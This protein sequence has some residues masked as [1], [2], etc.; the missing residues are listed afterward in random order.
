VKYGILSQTHPEYQAER[1]AELEVLYRG[2]AAITDAWRRKFLP[3]HVNETPARY[4]N[5]IQAAAYL[6]YFG[7]VV[8]FFATALFCKTLSLRAANGQV[9]EV[10]YAAFA[11]DADRKGNSFEAIIKQALTTAMVKRRSLVAV[12]LPRPTT[13]PTSRFEEERLG[14]GVPYAYEVPLEQ[15]IDWQLGDDGSFRWAILKRV[16]CERTSPASTRA[17]FAEEF[18]LWE[19]VDGDVGRRAAW[20]LFRT[21]EQRVDARRA[22]PPNRDVPEIDAGV[23]SFTR[24]PLVQLELP[25]ELCLGE[26]VGGAAKEHFQRRSALIA[27]EDR[28]L[29]A[30]PYVTLGPQVSGV[31]E[32]VLADVAQDHNRGDDPAEQFIRRGFMVLA[33]D[34]KV[35]FAE[36]SGAAYELTDRQLD[37]LVDEIFRVAHQMAQSIKSTGTALERS[38]TSKRE[39]RHA[40]EIVLGAFGKAVRSLA[41]NIYDTIAGGRGEDVYWQASGLDSYEIWDR[42]ELVAEGTQVKQVAIP[43]KTFQREYFG[44]VAT[45]LLGDVTPETLATI[46]DEIADA[47]AN[48]PAPGEATQAPPS[49]ALDGQHGPPSASSRADA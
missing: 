28:S 4:E 9:E 13:A 12:D 30:I 42:A 23:T 17:T 40:T 29:F 25:P 14:L 44:Q 18:K 31:G 49:L 2:G 32:P 39:D 26:I 48:A 36:P 35:G 41:T 10:A 1:W 24:I 11:E 33:G 8:N 27:S 45:R 15:L 21:P 46:R 37:K 38:G 3:P 43:S 22:Y 34:D 16:I 47:V 6:N 20:R 19:L 7:R 5:R